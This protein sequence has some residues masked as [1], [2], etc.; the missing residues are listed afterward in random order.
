M[1]FTA[2]WSTPRFRA[3]ANRK[4]N[5]EKKNC[6][7]L[8]ENFMNVIAS[9]THEA[10]SINFAFLRDS[11]RICIS[12]TRCRK[13]CSGKSLSPLLLAWTFHCFSVLFI[14]IIDRPPNWGNKRDSIYIKCGI[15][16][17]SRRE[18]SALP[19][20]QRSM[21]SAHQHRNIALFDLRVTSSCE[22]LDK[23]ICWPHTKR[24]RV[25]TTQTE[26]RFDD[27]LRLAQEGTNQRKTS[28]TNKPFIRGI[29]SSF[30]FR[31]SSADF[32]SSLSLFADR[33]F[34]FFAHFFPAFVDTIFGGE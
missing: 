31:S 12:D 17:R 1:I 18:K 26:K 9:R 5:C 30:L 24:L 27:G 34:L 2:T 3:P 15:P 4:L 23:Q 14:F 25:Q 32:A 6:S 28:T 16:A 13:T 7:T 19:P 8:V 20:L 10:D 21:V 33:L 29:I 11:L 22:D